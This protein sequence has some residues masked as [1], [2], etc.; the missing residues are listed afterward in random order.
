MP[1][2]EKRPLWN[3]TRAHTTLLIKVEVGERGEEGMTAKT[4]FKENVNPVIFPPRSFT[5]TS[6]PHTHLGS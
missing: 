1:W 6:R 4:M 3:K 5:V 2:P